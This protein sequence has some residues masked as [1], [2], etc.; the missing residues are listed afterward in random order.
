VN[1]VTNKVYVANSSSNNV[2]VI[3]PSIDTLLPLTTAVTSTSMIAGLANATASSAPS[4]TFTATSTYAPTAPAIRTVYYQLDSATGAWI[5][6]TGSGPF[7]AT[8]SSQ[9]KGSHVL[10]AY[11]VDGLE[12]GAA[13]GS[14]G[15]GSGNSPIVG[16]VVAYPISVIDPL[17]QAIV[18]GSNPGPVT[19]APSGTF[20]VGAMSTSGLTVSFSSTTTGVCTVSGST[21]TIVTAG[22]CIIAANQ[23]GNTNYNPAPEVTQSI[24]ISAPLITFTGN[25][26]SRK[27]HGNGVGVKDLPLADATING[28]FTVEPRTAGGGGHQIVFRFT[29]P[30]TSVT[31]VSVT[32]ATLANVGNPGVAFAGNDLIVTLNGVGDTTRLTVSV[33][34]VNSINGLNVS[35]AVGFLV[36]DVNQTRAVTAADIAAIKVRTS[37]LVDDSNYQFDINLSGKIDGADVSV[38]KAR[39]GRVIP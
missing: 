21:V 36:G 17:A 9:S 30:V 37:P 38:V 31:S 33:A 20:N 19:Y 39:A 23:A 6:A 5:Q 14:Y 25:A 24:T 11:A 2:T 35:R 3:T 15:I 28:A 34:G 32:D 18:F 1:P 10:Y 12:G 7:T 4:F 13:A 8:L 26:Y 22:T 27:T 16:S 29:N